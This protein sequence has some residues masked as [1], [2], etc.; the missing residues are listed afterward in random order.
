[1]TCRSWSSSIA[2]EI[3]AAIEFAEAG[4]LEPV[5]DLERFVYAEPA[6]PAA[7]SAPSPPG[8]PA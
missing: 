5:Q 6:P 8:A 2:Q 4:T 7:T 1:M 3:E